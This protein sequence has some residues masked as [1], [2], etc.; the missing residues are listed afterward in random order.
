MPV[1]RGYRKVRTME[2]RNAAK[3][4]GTLN[5]LCKCGHLRTNHVG[6]MH[7][8]SCNHTGPDHKMICGCIR[9]TWIASVERVK[10]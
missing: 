5:A 3:S 4:L 2:Q 8:G 1:P 10:L 6:E 7:H 9:F